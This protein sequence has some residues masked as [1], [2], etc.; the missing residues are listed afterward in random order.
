MEND[1]FSNIKK[2]FPDQEL[3][4]DHET[5]FISKLRN[6][7][8]EVSRMLLLQRIAIAAS[9][10]AFIAL[11]LLLALNYEKMKT[12]GKILYAVSSELY[13]TEQYL[14]GQIEGKLNKLA[15]TPAL[16]N[17]IKKD[18]RE[19]DL[20]FR[21]IKKDLAENPNDV[22]LI[23]AVIETY[24]AKISVLDIIIINYDENNI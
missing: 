22:R 8:A 14:S 3:P 21:E 17:D 15:L 16:N 4:T 9:V 5:R 6:R 13:E 19:I 1:I 23:N 10:A 11:S 12:Q 20:S 24:R 2:I 18:L 7:H